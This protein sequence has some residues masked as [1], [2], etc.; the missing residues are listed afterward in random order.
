MNTKKHTH[1][2]VSLC[3]HSELDGWKNPNQLYNITGTVVTN[4]VK[5]WIMNDVSMIPS[6]GTFTVISWCLTWPWFIR[7][8]CNLNGKIIE[9]SSGF[10]HCHVPVLDG[11]Q[12]H[13]ETQ[14]TLKT[15]EPRDPSC[16]CQLSYSP[17]FRF[18]GECDTHDTVYTSNR[19]VSI[20]WLLTHFSFGTWCDSVSNDHQIRKCEIHRNTKSNHWDSCWRFIHWVSHVYPS[21]VSSLDSRFQQVTGR[22]AWLGVQW[23]QG[24]RYWNA[25]LLS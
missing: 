17:E 16:G 7:H 24:S 9:L 18:E 22:A 23:G 21:L 25:T 2:H 14:P 5:Q 20:L 11:N 8:T 12:V 19:C 3:I 15:P 1:T 10:S 6:Q 4:N 13:E